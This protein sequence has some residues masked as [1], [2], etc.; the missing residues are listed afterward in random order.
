MLGKKTKKHEKWIK[1]KQI[2]KN[3]EQNQKKNNLKG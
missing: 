1:I 3:K 2:K